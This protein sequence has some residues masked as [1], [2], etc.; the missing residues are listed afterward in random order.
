MK[1]MGIVQ[2]SAEQAQELIVGIDTVYAHTNIVPV[3]KD[4]EGKP[5]QGLF[6]FN[7]VQYGKD[8]YIKV[9]AEKN[10]ELEIQ[11]TDTQLAL[12]EIYESMG[13]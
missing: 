8:E 7:E 13:V 2:G 9:M 10:G 4:A 1:N 11:L 12:I 3:T 6:Q 5:I